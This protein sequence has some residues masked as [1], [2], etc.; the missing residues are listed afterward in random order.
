MMGV[1][2]CLPA[3]DAFPIDSATINETLLWCT[4]IAHSITRISTPNDRRIHM[5]SRI[6]NRKIRR[7][8]GK[9]MKCA[10]MKWTSKWRKRGRG[11]GVKRGRGRDHIV[12]GKKGISNRL[13]R[14]RRWC[15]CWCCCW[16]W[17]CWCRRNYSCYHHIFDDKIIFV[18]ITL[19]MNVW[20]FNSTKL[21]KAWPRTN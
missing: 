5:L 20:M 14:K 11:T 10:N 7:W 8:K 2:A 13:K 21:A 3:N 16:W 1:W 17:W 18:M 9:I 19:K 12:K 6:A 15:W 4:D